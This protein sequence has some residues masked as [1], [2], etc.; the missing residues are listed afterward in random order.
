MPDTNLATISAE[1]PKKIKRMTSKTQRMIGTIILWI[2]MLLL[3]IMVIYPLLF[4]LSTSFKEY[5]EFLDKPFSLSL[6]HPENYVKAW[7]DGHFSVYFF[8]SV[9]VTG[10]TVVAKVFMSALVAYCIAVLK[11]R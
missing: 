2:I 9:L 4:V 7:V 10:T 3:T 8:N 6:K 5:A 11:I 1:R